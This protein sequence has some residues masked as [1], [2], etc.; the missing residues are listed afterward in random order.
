[1]F[2]A[3]AVGQY[4]GGLDERNLL[5]PDQLSKNITNIISTSTTEGFVNTDSLFRADL[6]DI[7]WSRDLETQDMVPLVAGKRIANLHIHSKD[8][9]RWMTKAM[10]I[11]PDTGKK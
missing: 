6:V 11:L 3:R 10:N 7:Q 2:D 8:L 1:M 5:D 9:R 4:I